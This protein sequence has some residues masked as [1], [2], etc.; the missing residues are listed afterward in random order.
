MP[1]CGHVKYPLL[2]RAYSPY[3]LPNMQARGDALRFNETFL[4]TLPTQGQRPVTF[5]HSASPCAAYAPLI[6]P[7]MG[8]AYQGNLT[9]LQEARFLLPERRTW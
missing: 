4:R 3:D 6:R 7:L 1:N 2:Y 9:I 5:Q 8:K